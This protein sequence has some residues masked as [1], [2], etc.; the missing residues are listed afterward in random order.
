VLGIDVP[1]MTAKLGFNLDP[2]NIVHFDADYLL[3]V[4]DETLNAKQTLH[5]LM[6]SPLWQRITAVRQHHVLEISVYRQ[7]IGCGILGKERM[8]DDVLACVRLG[9][10]VHE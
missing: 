6:A 9:D 10:S 7:W 3:V 1:P 4:G 5:R 8:I 2:E